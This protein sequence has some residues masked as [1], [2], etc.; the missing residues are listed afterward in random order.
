MFKSWGSKLI[1]FLT[2][3]MAFIRGIVWWE[4]ATNL[5][6]CDEW[7]WRIPTWNFRT[8]K[9]SLKNKHMDSLRDPPAVLNDDLYFYVKTTFRDNNQ[10]RRLFFGVRIQ[11]TFRPPIFFGPGNLHQILMRRCQGPFSNWW[12]SWAC[13]CSQAHPLLCRGV[14]IEVEDS[15]K[16]GRGLSGSLRQED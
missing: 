8:K 4:K 12:W 14:G 9:H 11:S 7:S 10:N 16:T 2:F 1:V 13:L 3:H 6:N 15:P 5:F